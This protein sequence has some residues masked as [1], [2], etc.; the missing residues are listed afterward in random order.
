MYN[1]L[2]CPVTKKVDINTSAS[3]S[4]LKKYI[5]LIN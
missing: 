5:K 3:I 2:Y 1:T 4:V